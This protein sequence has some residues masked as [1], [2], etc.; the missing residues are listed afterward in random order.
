M[1]RNKT[2]QKTWQENR[3]SNHPPEWITL[4]YP[5]QGCL[6]TF[7][8]KTAAFWVRAQRFLFFFPLSFSEHH[9]KSSSYLPR[10]SGHSFLMACPLCLPMQLLKGFHCWAACFRPPILKAELPFSFHCFLLASDCPVIF[11]LNTPLELFL[12]FLLAPFL[13]PFICKTKNLEEGLS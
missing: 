4:K 10:R 1:G 6:Q 5:T 9:S 2:H 3:R 11:S 7:T 12:S 13:S 8:A